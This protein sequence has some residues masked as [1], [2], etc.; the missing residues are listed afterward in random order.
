MTR[1]WRPLQQTTPAQLVQVDIAPLAE[2]TKPNDS[3]SDTH[4]VEK[5]RVIGIKR[6]HRIGEWHAPNSR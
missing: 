3:T 2:T 5:I 6:F 4:F 1:S